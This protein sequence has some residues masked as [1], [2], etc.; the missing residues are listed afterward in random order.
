MAMPLHGYFDYNATTPVCDE[1]VQAQRLVETEFANPSGK[2]GMA[3]KAKEALALAREQVARMIN[4]NSDEI[5]FTSGGTEGNNWAIKGA[6][7]AQGAFCRRA[8]P[9]HVI[10]SE[11]EHASVLEAASYLERIF[12]C[13]VTRLR[14]NAEGIV[15]ASALAAAL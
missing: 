14:P 6:L 11:I 2:Y 15:S 4:S 3:K 8:E 5:A 7:A 1:A 10:V 9:A 13:E 12:D